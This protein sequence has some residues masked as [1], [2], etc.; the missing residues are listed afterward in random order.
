MRIKNTGF[1]LIELPVAKK[2]GFTLIE[3]IIVVAIIAIMAGIASVAIAGSRGKARDAVRKADMHHLRRAFHQYQTDND[4]FPAADE[5]WGQVPNIDAIYIKNM[6]TDP[7]VTTPFLYATHD[8]ATINDVEFGI[9]CILETDS[10]TDTGEASGSPLQITFIS[11]PASDL[12]LTQH[13]NY[14]VTSF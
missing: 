5:S 14:S 7:T 10:D 2:R 1:T 8:S 3:L 11:D 9:E 6:P 4:V 12:E 13:Y